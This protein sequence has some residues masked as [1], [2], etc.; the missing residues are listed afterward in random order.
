MALLGPPL[1][2]A[3]RPLFPC[4][5]KAGSQ[6]FLQSGQL[7]P[8]LQARGIKRWPFCKGSHWQATP[9]MQDQRSVAKG[10]SDSPVP[11]GAH[12]QTGSGLRAAGHLVA[13]QGLS[14]PSCPPRPWLQAG[15]QT[16]L[17]ALI[18]WTGLR[19]DWPSRVSFAIQ[20]DLHRVTQT[21]R[22]EKLGRCG[23]VGRKGRSGRGP[24]W[25][26]ATGRGFSGLWDWTI[27]RS[28]GPRRPWVSL[29]FQL[30]Q[31]QPPPDTENLVKATRARGS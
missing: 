15:L 16:G 13:A 17:L 11:P 2:G 31:G 12:R 10:S 1:A 9:T 21:P 7:Q 6:P 29:P 14:L 26:S 20:T 28:L 3:N 25:G 5:G 24:R 23:E 22:L 27:M 30:P 19:A 4:E 18:G 8:L